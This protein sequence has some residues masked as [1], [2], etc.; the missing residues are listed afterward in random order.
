MKTVTGKSTLY[1]TSLLLAAASALSGCQSDGV[2]EGAGAAGEGGSGKPNAAAAALPDKYDPPIE[3]TT[4]TYTFPNLKYTNGDDVNN[5]PWTR[6]LERDFGIKVKTLWAVPADQYAQKANLMIATG[7]LP[8]F[9]PATPT[10]FKQLHEAGLL[11]DLTDTYARY[12]PDVVRRVMDEAGP[13]PLQSA[14][15]DGRLMAIPFTGVAKESGPVLWIRKDWMKKL[16]LSEPK[17]LDDVFAISEAFTKRDPDGNGKPDTFGLGMD[18]TLHS[19]FSFGIYNGYHAYSRIWI[20]DKRDDKLVYSSIQPEMKRALAKLQQ[21]Y[22]DGQLDPEFP[23]KTSAKVNESFGGN[24]I[25]MFYGARGS[26]NFPLQQS[27]PN[28]EW[29]AYPMPSIDGE[30]A[31]PQHDLNIFSYYWVVKKGAPHPEALLKMLELWLNTNYFNTSDAVYEQYNQSADNNTIWQMAPV[32]MYRSIHNID[33][34]RRIAAVMKGESDASKLGPQEKVVYGH[35]REYEKGEMKYW[36]EFAQN[37]PNSSGAVL[38]YYY[39]NNLYVANRF[40]TT[41]TPAM[42][43][44]MPNLSKLEQETFTKIVL[45]APIDEFDKFVDAWK[46]QGGDEVTKEVN[47]WYA[48][49]R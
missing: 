41:P 29:Q 32:K 31:R 34:Y 42:I 49:Q 40:Y 8:D 45:G 5:N 18:N 3:M 7:N 4:V 13:E 20:K 35:I 14:H 24:R 16:N 2:P 39:K 38:D 12:A 9:F 37:S 48:D 26:A 36:G 33:V 21:L 46:R 17:T 27:T 25:G 10:Q 23:V 30:P 22:K 15:I 47:D 28:V 44:K 43:D 1:L 6:R 19:T 11:A